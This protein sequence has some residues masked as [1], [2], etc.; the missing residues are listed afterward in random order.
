MTPEL[1]E[2]LKQSSAR[3]SH[4]CPRQVL[5]VRMGL[6]GLKA[7]GLDAPVNKHTGLVIVETDGCFADGVQVATGAAVGHRTLR[8]HDL[9]LI[10][11]TLVNVRTGGAIRFSP[12]PDV[13]ERAAF[14]A[15]GLKSR[16]SIQ[17]HGYQS[18]PEGELLRRQ[19][20]ILQP[21]L[22][23][24]LSKPN[25]RVRCSRCGEEIINDRQV[26]AGESVLCRAC[27]GLG[28]YRLPG[29]LPAA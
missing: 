1:T 16:Y 11:M 7:L 13:R 10:A 20:V 28:Y 22:S 12:Q 24:I 14:Y 19:N 6:A 4:L 29:A 8:V 17:L 27:A 26:R 18:M 9:G 25:V 3:H 23:E 2:L 5:G 21:S 15:P